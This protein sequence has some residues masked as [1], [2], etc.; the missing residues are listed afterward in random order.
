M[1]LIVKKKSRHVGWTSSSRESSESKKKIQIICLSVTSCR[2]FPSGYQFL[3]TMSIFQLTQR[4]SYFLYN[5][6]IGSHLQLH[7]TFLIINTTYIYRNT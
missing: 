4:I 3:L 5:V 6:A 7:L 2:P 1:V